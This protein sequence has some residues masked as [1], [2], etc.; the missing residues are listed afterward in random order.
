M[1]KDILYTIPST[2]RPHNVGRMQEFVQ[3]PLW[4]VKDRKDFKDYVAAGAYEVV[5]R[6]EPSLRGAR[7]LAIHLAGLDGKY[8]LQLDDD[9][10]WV[11]AASGPERHLL[12]D[13]EVED[14][15]FQMVWAMEAVDTGVCGILT[16]NN[17]RQYQ[18]FVSTWA[19]MC[20]RFLLI[21]PS[22]NINFGS[23]ETDFKEDWELTCKFMSEVGR[24]ARLGWILAS[25]S[26]SQKGGLAARRT[27]EL[28]IQAC[29]RLLN[30]YPHILRKN[31]KRIGQIQLKHNRTNMPETAKVAFAEVNA[32][33]RGE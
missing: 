9:L 13:V 14:V 11:K 20:A 7:N 22:Y 3:Q 1:S 17:H 32:T 4:I 27:T 2:R 31:T 25:N 5:I 23:S 6:K 16:T 26:G 15:A 30:T 12:E 33:E 10:M 8:N 19:F 18:P 21:D 28:E 24:V 29:R